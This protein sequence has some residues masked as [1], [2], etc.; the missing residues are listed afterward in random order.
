M[1]I[2]AWLMAMIAPMAIRAIIGLGFTIVT[3]GGVTIAANALLVIAQN[4]WS[5]IDSGLLQLAE[6]GGVPECIGMIAGAYMAKIAVWAAMNGAKY[7]L[8]T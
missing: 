8:K 4:N 5:A 1:R 6:A 7:V 2:V 3:F